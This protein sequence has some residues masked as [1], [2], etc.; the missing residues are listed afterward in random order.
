MQSI[1]HV[2]QIEETAVGALEGGCCCCSCWAYSFPDHVQVLGLAHFHVWS[3]NFWWLGQ[4]FPVSL[5][6]LDAFFLGWCSLGCM[7]STATASS[8]SS[9]SSGTAA[10]TW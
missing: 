8:S 3:P 1:D 6:G 5:P 2:Q 7:L 9:L 10:A 4:S